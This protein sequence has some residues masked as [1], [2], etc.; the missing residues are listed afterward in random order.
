VDTRLLPADEHEPAT[1]P[2]CPTEQQRAGP[3]FPSHAE[4]EAP[5]LAGQARARRDERPVRYRSPP[6]CRAVG[7]VAAGQAAWVAE[8]RIPA[9]CR[10]PGR[11]RPRWRWSGADRLRAR[12]PRR[13][14]RLA[15]L[16]DLM[17]RRRRSSRVDSPCLVRRPSRDTRPLFCRRMRTRYK[18]VESGVEEDRTMRRSSTAVLTGPPAAIATGAVSVADSLKGTADART[19]DRLH[20]VA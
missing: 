13:D 8:R 12:R 20:H 17:F 16:G 1:R 18:T 15:R 4:G 3:L 19:N 10:E 14:G 11:A 5:P 6:W 9:G 2:P 7:A